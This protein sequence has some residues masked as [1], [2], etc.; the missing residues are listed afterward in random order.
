MKS[1]N[2]QFLVDDLGNRTSVLLSLSDYEALL[3]EV[4]DAEDTKLF[5]ESMQELNEDSISLDE[6]MIKR[7]LMNE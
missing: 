5:E 6:Y 1:I 2:P 7:G 3:E 4:E